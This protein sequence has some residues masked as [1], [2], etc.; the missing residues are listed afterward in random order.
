MLK[1][2]WEFTHN[3][4]SAHISILEF[5]KSGYEIEYI[6][7]SED[8]YGFKEKEAVKYEDEYWRSDIISLLNKMF[9][10]SVSENQVL[11]AYY[12]DHKIIKS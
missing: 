11:R 10:K 5:I 9:G 2:T 8:N 12:G 3:Y 7:P 6:I 4:K 1:L